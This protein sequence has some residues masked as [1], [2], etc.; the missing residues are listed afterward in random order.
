MITLEK[1][2]TAL[3]NSHDGIAIMGN[4]GTIS[5]VNQSHCKLFGYDQISELMGK[6]WTIHFHDNHADRM[7]QHVFPTVHQNGFWAGEVF[8]RKKDGSHI[9][10]YITLAKIIDEGILCICRDESKDL[11]LGRL[12][13]LTTNLGKGIVVEDEFQRI[14]LANRQFCN[15]FQIQFQQE[16]FIGQTV[17]DVIK[18]LNL[19]IKNIDDLKIEFELISN[20]KEPLYEQRIYLSDGRTLEMDYLPIY[21]NGKFKG[22]LWTYTDATDQIKLQNSFI[23]AKNKAMASEKAKTAFLSYMSHEIRTPMNAILGLSEQ[24]SFSKLDE[25]QSFFVKN[26]RDSAKN[27]LFIIN[28]ILDLSKIEA[29][30]MSFQKHPFKLRSVI[31]SVENILKPKAEEKGLSFSIEYDNTINESHYSDEI[32]IRQIL[33]NIISNAI[34]FTQKGYIKITFKN[35]G[36]DKS[37]QI[38]EFRCLDTGFG[39]SK[40]ALNHLF[41]D[42][43]QDNQIGKNIKELGS[44]LGLAITRS[45]V[46][47]IGG[48]IDI[49][50]T[51]NSG[52]LVCIQLPLEI[53]KI[54]ILEIKGTNKKNNHLLEGKRMLLVEDNNL[55]RMVFRM[56]L[57]NLKIVIDESENGFEALEKIA[58]NKYDLVLM[59]IH[60]PVMDGP[61]ALFHIIKSHGDTIPVIAL[62]A[63]AFKSEVNHLLMLGF[64]DC[65]TKP[66]DQQMLQEKL[67]NYFS[68]SHDKGKNEKLIQDKIIKNL[69]DLSQ[70]DK[71]QE[72]KLYASLLEEIN[73]AL[74]SWKECIK[75]N[76]WDIA[77]KTLH[78][79]KVMINSVGI[80]SYDLLI[81]E[82]EDDSLHKSESE[83]KLMYM[84]LIKLFQHI[85]DRFEGV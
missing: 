76:S 26:I 62:T 55:N 79:Q 72:S 77:K 38:I 78:R 22:Q 1:L 28:D 19:I 6:P 33:I 65:I 56:M 71:V 58:K 34:K 85:K 60:M 39:I 7:N 25:E 48:K 11:N 20:K 2:L 54:N 67:G 61:T 10:Q 36:V 46:K 4:D 51:V 3:D 23:E 64:S 21:L 84:Q 37:S 8:G 83:H 66:V 80:D 49:N 52:T 59:D 42:F 15:L 30:K 18:K 24:L 70:G 44:G 5:Y 53:Q 31:E 32:R 47:L 35:L 17:S 82:L 9:L 69:L 43:F 57:N 73:L 14:V 63:S 74:V 12:E 40:S 16:E 29:G 41:E 81:H 45:I 75:T 50:S 13:Y 27:L 68:I